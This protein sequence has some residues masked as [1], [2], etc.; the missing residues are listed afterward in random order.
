MGGFS[1]G[2]LEALGP[3]IVFPGIRI[4]NAQIGLRE[5][6]GIPTPN[7]HSDGLRPPGSIRVSPKVSRLAPRRALVSSLIF[8]DKVLQ[9]RGLCP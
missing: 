8:R 4:L 3:E 9:V 5:S 1:S 6:R 2:W 7:Y